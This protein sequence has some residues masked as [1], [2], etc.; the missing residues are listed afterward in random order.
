M[1]EKYKNSLYDLVQ[2]RKLIHNV[3]ELFISI[4][5]SAI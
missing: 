2:Y 3:I 4:D 5:E 1:S